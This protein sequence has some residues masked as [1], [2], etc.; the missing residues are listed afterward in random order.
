M[1]RTL[2][3]IAHLI[4]VARCQCPLPLPH[5]RSLADPL[6][7]LLFDELSQPLGRCRVRRRR[8]LNRRRPPSPRR[9]LD[10]Y[11]HRRTRSPHSLAALARRTRT[12]ICI[13]I[14]LRRPLVARASLSRTPATWLRCPSPSPHTHARTLSLS[15]PHSHSPPQ[16][17]LA[18][19]HCSRNI[20]RPDLAADRHRCARIRTR[21]RT[22]KSPHRTR[23][24][25]RRPPAT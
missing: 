18:A 9:P 22:R 11:H 13:C 12:R 2:T 16:N 24:R 6:D 7:P 25:I 8:R 17:P 3:C 19:V 20:L 21:T 1:H 23:T 15:L 14:R 4:Q 5:A 10:V